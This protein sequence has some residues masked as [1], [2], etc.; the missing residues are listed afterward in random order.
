MREDWPRH[1]WY[2]QLHAELT[3]AEDLARHRS[4]SKLRR[5]GTSRTKT[6]AGGGARREALLNPKS[7][8]RVNRKQVGAG[9][10]ARSQ[11]GRRSACMHA[12]AACFYGRW[13]CRRPVLKH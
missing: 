12:A 6:S 3:D 10:A 9:W 13:L 11:S 5:Q 4:A 8:R 2:V 7:H 1:A